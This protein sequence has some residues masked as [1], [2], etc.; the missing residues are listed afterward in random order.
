M[1]GRRRC[2]VRNEP[3]EVKGRRCFL[4]N[5]SC[6]KLARKIGAVKIAEW[7][8]GEEMSALAFQSALTMSETHL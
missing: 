2:S 7:K 1:V 5:E 6:F 8:G 3:V 4:G